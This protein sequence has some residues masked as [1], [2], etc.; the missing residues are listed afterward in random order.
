VRW[1]WSRKR[2]PEAAERLRAEA[3]A[4]LD[5]G[6]GETARDRLEEALAADPADARAL[7]ALVE[8]L[9]C[10]L[11]DPEAALERLGRSTAL[12]GR[13]EGDD[14]RHALWLEAEARA[15]LGDPA[16]ALALHERALASAPDDAWHRA[17]RGQRLFELA[18]FEDARAELE[19]ARAAL[20]RLD[21][22]E[23]DPATLYALASLLERD[24][25][26]GDA[27]RLFARA[28]DLDPDAFA[29]PVRLSSR[30]FDRAVEEALASLPEEFRAHL[31]N[32]VVQT[33]DVPPADLLRETGH[34]PLILGLYEG[35]NVADTFAA[36]GV[37]V[38]Q[39]SRV[40]LYKR[41]IEK[42]ATT[43][44]E[45]VEQIRITVLHEVGHHLGYDDHGLDEIGLG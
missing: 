12:A 13:L 11:D 45:V 19:A 4:A 25:R 7:L 27:D 17:G 40:T 28:E 3:E 2:D 33:L 14:A 15:T 10:E 41:N 39:P 36:D 37:P 34:D 1:P 38:Q 20:A 22:P 32:V 9:L 23:D 5:D 42:A 16:A 30:A 29:R 31:A 26:L 43:R 24:D 8:V 35:I 44:D 21:P 18:R 6:E